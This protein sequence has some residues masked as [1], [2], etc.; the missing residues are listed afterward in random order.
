MEEGCNSIIDWP[1]DPSFL[2]LRD[3]V[4][5][6]DKRYFYSPNRDGLFY[7]NELRGLL[8]DASANIGK[9]EIGR[10][11]IFNL[12]QIVPKDFEL[13]K[14]DGWGDWLVSFDDAENEIIR[15]ILN[16][17]KIV[18]IHPGNLFTNIPCCSLFRQ[19][20]SKDG[21]RCE[22]KCN[23][24]DGR[25]ALLY[26]KE[27]PKINHKEDWNCFNDKL[28][29][30]INNYNNV[31]GPND[32]YLIK[33]GTHPHH[34]ENREIVYRPYVYYQCKYS[35]FMEYSF[36]V[37]HA[38]KV[39][40]VLM[41][42]QCFPSNLNKDDI[43]KEYRGGTDANRKNLDKWIN[44]NINEEDLSLHDPMD[45]NRLEYI[46]RQIRMLEGKVQDA[47]RAIS[48]EYVSEQFFEIER[49]FRRQIN[50]VG[51]NTI[52]NSN[53]KLESLRKE[54]EDLNGNI[55]NYSK[56][57]K[58]TLKKIL[59]TFNLEGFIRIYFI[60]SPIVNQV[61]TNKDVFNIIGDSDYDPKNPN[62]TYS[63]IIFNKIKKRNGTLDKKD[64]LE[65]KTDQEEPYLPEKYW[66][67]VAGFDPQA[68]DIFRMQFSFSYQ[69]A[70]I[71]W[72]KYDN[73]DI[74]SEQYGEYVT[75]WESM[76]HTLLEPYVIYERMRLEKDL[77][78]TMRISSHESAQ[79]IPL[80]I[81][82]I[83]SQESYE[84]LA[85][86]VGKYKGPSEIT[87]PAKTIIDAS[88][89]LSLLS[90]LFK[91][92]S[93]I[94]KDEKPDLKYFDFHRIIYAPYS[95]FQE[96]AFS[97]KYQSI[98]IRIDE[99]L[100]NYLLKTDYDYLSH[101]LF[102]LMDNAIKYGLRGSNI[103]INARLHR[104]MVGEVYNIKEV[105]ISV[106]SY[107]DKI[108]DTDKEK[109]FELY[110]H[111]M[112]AERTEGM[113]IGLFLVKKLCNLLEYK[114]ECLSTKIAN[115]NLPLKYHY[116]MQNPYYLKYLSLYSESREIL[117][118][119][120]EDNIKEAVNTYDLSDK[121]S[122]TVD[123]LQWGEKPELSRSTYKNEF[124]ITIPIKAGDLK[125]Q[126]L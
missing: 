54:I 68:K 108:E 113:G 110:Y 77:E 17:R 38:G 60:E 22:H 16:D 81:N 125:R 121:W 61:N 26:D 24:M 8:A 6:Y 39:I 59:E 58:H 29:E 103:R 86:E 116:C 96:E 15:T 41:H 85:D 112:N 42:G 47:V 30:I 124:K 120:F 83:N 27:L 98:T 14:S 50:W 66:G 46:S 102:N 122:I 49:R 109:I 123:H 43:F 105:T 70:Y 20:T 94:F 80:V 40:A 69:I 126:M 88:H 11:D 51:K 89:R 87:K 76:Y 31:I 9:G 3:G 65:L 104:K 52:S 92:L 75:Y 84:F 13:D 117:K 101:I 64:L 1:I 63:K 62:H 73:V 21:K 111:S 55:K 25:I 2:S 74:E 53:D 91:R 78:S 57:L 95:L 90:G 18:R 10:G 71:I 5:K 28:K 67:K 99:D 107:G 72:E 106:V 34:N 119:K 100:K 93:D 118:K 79:V 115:Y 97:D 35:H 12:F 33:F 19:C 37:F 82:M 4:N 114:I 7:A 45:N 44:N 32:P 23:E 48:K 36:P 56:I